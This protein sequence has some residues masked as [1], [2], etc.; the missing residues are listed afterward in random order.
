MLF[1]S[2]EALHRRAADPA[3]AVAKALPQLSSPD[4]FVRYAARVA[5]EHQP[6]E[7]WQDKVLAVKDPRGV[8]AA[9]I[10]VTHQAEPAAQAAVF[11]ALDRIDPQSLDVAGRIDLVRA[12]ELAIVRLGEPTADVKARIAARF[13]PLFPSGTFDLD[14][15]L[16]SLLVGVREIGRAHV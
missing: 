4:R 9:A 10:G 15:A 13:A 7:L 14:K 3:A 8:I 1:R 12:Y 2:L 6:L 5:L 11:A 16:S